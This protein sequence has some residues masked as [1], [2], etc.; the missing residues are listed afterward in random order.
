[1]FCK[2]CGKELSDNAKFCNACGAETMPTPAENVCA[3]Q[4]IP[5]PVLEQPLQTAPEV[6]APRKAVPPVAIIIGAVAAV[7][8][9][10]LTLLL[11]GV[12]DSDS[13][14]VFKALEKSGKAFEHAAEALDLPDLK[15]IQADKAYSVDFGFQIN[16]VYGAEEINDLGLTGSADFSLSDKKMGMTLTPSY[17]SVELLNM[18]MK[19]D[20]NMLYLNIPEITGETGYS[21][22]TETVFQ[23]V[24]RFT[25]IPEELADVRINVM[26]LMRIMDEKMMYTKEDQK[27]VDE[28]IVALLK[29]IEA[30]KTDSGEITVNGNDMK[31]DQ[32]HVVVP[33]HSLRDYFSVL[34]NIMAEKNVAQAMREAYIAMNIPTEEMDFSDLEMGTDE[35]MDELDDMLNALGDIELEVYLKGGYVMAVIFE[36]DMDG[37]EVEFV[38]NI[39]GGENYVDDLSLTVSDDYTTI[40]MESSGNHAAKG[41]AFTDETVMYVKEDGEKYVILDSSL[42]FD[43]KSKAENFEWTLDMDESADMA[44]DICGSVTFT[45]SSMTVD[46][47]DICIS[48]YGQELADLSVYYQVDPYSDN[49]QIPGTVELLKLSENEILE[50]IEALSARVETWAMGLLDKIPE[51]QYLLY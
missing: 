51:L 25:E 17:G 34:A 20:N 42:S 19:L 33:E 44:L 37:E 46:L 45:G 30:E 32:Y 15:Y 2:N 38:L 23:D 31:C 35:I 11:T 16:E 40:V 12:F 48:E 39:G 49:I 43:T 7:A 47:T 8:V 3:E 36:A 9:L 18:Q 14:R 4:S 29:S 10:V 6:V 5:A 24:S 28:A 26:E 1:M 50:E 27:K 21:M 41:G 13:T 22:N